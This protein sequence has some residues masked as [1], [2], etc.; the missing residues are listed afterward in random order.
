MSVQGSLIP[1]PMVSQKLWLDNRFAITA[2]LWDYVG[3]DTTYRENGY[4]GT[5]GILDRR[6]Y[7]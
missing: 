1:L 7:C 5:G 3:H 2:K 6:A 4:R